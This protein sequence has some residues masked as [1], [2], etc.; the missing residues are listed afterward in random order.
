M[1]MGRNLVNRKRRRFWLLSGL[2]VSLA[3]LYRL[4]TTNAVKGGIAP[5]PGGPVHL[6]PPKLVLS[7]TRAYWYSRPVYKLTNES[8]G[9]L[10]TV[11]VYNWAGNALTPLEIGIHNTKDLNTCPPLGNPPYFLKSGNSLWFVGSTE[12][13]AQFTVMWHGPEN[14]AEYEVLSIH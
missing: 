1:R 13:P 9:T 10:S 8:G 2:F 6:A 7:Q 14:Q 11:V 4:F 3:L 5:Q 12:P